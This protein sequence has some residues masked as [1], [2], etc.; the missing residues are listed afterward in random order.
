MKTSI[1]LAFLKAGFGARR[2]SRFRIGFIHQTLYFL[3]QLI[4]LLLEALEK[5]ARLGDEPLHGLKETRVQAGQASSPLDQTIRLRNV[6]AMDPYRITGGQN[7]EQKHEN[8]MHGDRRFS[9]R[10]TAPIP[11]AVA[12]RN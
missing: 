10:P 12:S 5:F 1:L 7:V 2:T 9:G 8:V 11:E 3:I 6:A 4:P